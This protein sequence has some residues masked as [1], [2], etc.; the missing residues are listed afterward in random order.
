MLTSDTTLIA[1]FES[2]QAIEDA[3]DKTAFVIR[4]IG[5]RIVVEG[6]ADETVCLF[7]CMGRCLQSV[8]ATE[9]CTFQVPAPDVY[10]LQVAGHP[11]QCVVV[12]G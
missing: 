2:I 6:I 5:T 4:T 1:Y 7:D 11:V 10:M 3:T 8:R 9:G 12:V